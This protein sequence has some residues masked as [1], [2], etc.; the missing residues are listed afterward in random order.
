[1]KKR[2]AKFI[3]FLIPLPAQRKRF[4]R[5]LLGKPANGSVPESTLARKY[6]DGLNG[7]E[8]GASTQNGFG[9]DRTGGA[10][11]SV[12]FEAT[13]GGKWQDSQFEPVKVNIVAN[14]DDLPFKDNTL[15]YVLS[16]HVI[17]HFFDPIKA[18]KEWSR[19]IRNGGYV[20][21]IVPH[22]ERTFDCNRTITSLDELINRHTGVLKIDDYAHRP[23][24]TTVSPGYGPETRQEL[25]DQP[26]LLIQDEGTPPGWLRFEQDDHHHW[27][28]WTTDNF[29]ELCRHLSLNVVETQDPDD[30]VGN[31][32]TVVIQKRI[33][34][35]NL[36]ADNP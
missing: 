10:Y 30:K 14:G 20:F 12:D 1:M 31:G 35:S 26:H 11:A 7:I 18:L 13:Q 21:I 6:L 27:T 24:E 16:S 5:R 17:E 32:F 29:L 36:R 8:I 34:H 3:S 4:R 28:V 33:P 19:V 25:L 15:D 2:T 9:L 23:A 22:K